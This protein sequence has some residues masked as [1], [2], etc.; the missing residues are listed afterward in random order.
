MHYCA[1]PDARQTRRP[2]TKAGEAARRK[3]KRNANSVKL[4]LVT[5]PFS[6]QPIPGKMLESL[7]GSNNN[8]SGMEDLAVVWSYR[9]HVPFPEL[10][11]STETDWS[12]AAKAASGESM[13]G[14]KNKG[15]EH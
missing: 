11:P 7:G 3:G 6:A 2:P 8:N 15:L 13:R 4:R 1:P 9:H 12:H 10:E 14:E 5:T